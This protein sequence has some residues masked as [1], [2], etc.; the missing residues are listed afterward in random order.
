MGAVTGVND[1]LQGT[2]LPDMEETKFWG[3]ARHHKILLYV[4]SE[5]KAKS[6][7]DLVRMTDSL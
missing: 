2:F 3:S 4:I 5:L 1:K 6:L 7:V